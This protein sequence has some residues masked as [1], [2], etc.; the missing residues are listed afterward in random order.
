MTTPV[1]PIMLLD[2]V[3]HAREQRTAEK[4]LIEFT[5]QAFHII[6]P[7]V[8]FVDN[9]H[10][11]AIADHLEAVSSGE[12]SNLLINIPPGC[13]KSILVSVAWPAWEWIKHPE[14]RY[15][16]ASYG[17]DL[18]I[19][20]AAKCR[21]IIMSDWYQER[22]PQVAVRKGADQKTKYELTSGGWRMATSVGGRA[23]GEHPDRKIV[24]DP[25]SAAQAD[26]DT[27]RRGGVT[28]FDRTLSTRGESRGART[29][30][31]MQRLHENDVSGHILSD[32]TSGYVHLCLP[33]EYDGQRHK[34][35]IGWEDPRT[36]RGSLLWPEMFPAE[37][38][39][40]LK[41]RLGSYGA[42]GQLQQRPAPEGG[43][44]LKTAHFQLWPKG[45][46]L[47]VFDLVVQSYDT[48]FSGEDAKQNAQTAHQTWGLAEYKGKRIGLLL[49]SWADHLAYP[50]LRARVLRDW[51][52]V[53]GTSPDDKSRKGRRPDN[54]LVEKKASGHSLLQDLRA[55]NVPA[56]A[57]SPTS[58]KVARAHQAAPILELDCLYIPESAKEPGTFVTW[59]RPLVEQ[60]EKFPNSELKD[61]VDAFTQF[62]IWARDANYFDLDF[63]E[64]EVP[65]EVDYH[66]QKKRKANPYAA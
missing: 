2:A 18:A 25:H 63:V 10:L 11:H 43:G 35:S 27:E 61:N 62:V 17:G 9:W 41:K 15:L 4:S 39:A 60:C 48:A 58:D 19:R 28:W 29:V 30:V 6:E 49:D 37:S 5:R 56:V 55:A 53:Y 1:S 66:A 23:T 46:P 24:D 7:G 64:A 38:V 14:L 20:D 12:I 33:M 21:D 13:M 57:Y 50:E 65:E 54:I 36:K 47:P 59:A 3:R 26:S 31:V 22:W 32:S 16:G 8:K 40:R 52:T 45:R 51:K 42:A 34:T 44:I